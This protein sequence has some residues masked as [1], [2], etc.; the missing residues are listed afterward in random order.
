MK[1]KHGFDMVA[2]TQAVF[3]LLLEALANPGRPVNLGQYAAGFAA[4]GQWL[5]LALTLLDNETGFY[6]DGLPETGEEIRF[7]SGGV[8]VPL[9]AADFV[10]LDRHGGDGGSTESEAARVLSIVKGG[11]HLDPHDS[12]LLVIG[13]GGSACENIGL[14]GPG[15]PP[16]GRELRLSSA[17]AAWVRARDARGFEYPCGVEL[18]FLRED[19]SLFAV[20]RKVEAAWRM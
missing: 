10:F 12:A 13:A 18:V 20:T 11:A 6:W 15:V 8:P 2:G 4:H 17:E 19:F 3:R 16:G 1:A 9:D 7:L 5:A 14:R